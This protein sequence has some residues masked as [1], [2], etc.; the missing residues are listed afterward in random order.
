MVLQLGVGRVVP[1]ALRNPQCTRSSV[2]GTSAAS[3]STW[4]RL[5]R[6]ENSASGGI[7]VQW[8]NRR[9]ALSLT[10]QRAEVINSANIVSLDTLALG[11]VWSEA[12][13]DQRVHE[14]FMGVRT[15]TPSFELVDEEHISNMDKLIGPVL[16]VKWM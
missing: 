8:I 1:V 2:L 15:C 4:L 12:S 14:R 7:A 13:G 9:R 3:G 5:R 16:I 6:Q 11:C 10:V